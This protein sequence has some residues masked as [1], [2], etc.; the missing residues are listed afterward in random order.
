MSKSLGPDRCRSNNYNIPERHNFTQQKSRQDSPQ[1]Q[2]KVSPIKSSQCED[3]VEQHKQ[4]KNHV[5]TVGDEAFA[6]HTTAV[7]LKKRSPLDHS[8][9][10]TLCRRDNLRA[11]ITRQQRRAN[12]FLG[13]LPEHSHMSR[14]ILAINH[15]ALSGPLPQSQQNKQMNECPECHVCVHHECNR[16]FESHTRAHARSIACTQ[17]SM[18][19]EVM[20]RTC[21]EAD[22]PGGIVLTT[23]VVCV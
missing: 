18:H 6:A 7:I 12:I 19:A 17:H 4:H 16:R 11:N 1:L 22:G 14:G 15:M 3:D 9:S 21:D 2:H 20:L 10:T 13:N 8:N 23:P 5:A